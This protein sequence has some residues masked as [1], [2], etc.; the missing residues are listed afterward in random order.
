MQK[1][2]AE[3]NEELFLQFD[4]A[5]IFIAEEEEEEEE[6]EPSIVVSLRDITERKRA[7]AQ[8]ATALESLRESEE[9][10]RGIF[11]SASDTFL[12][13]NPEGEIID[14]N[15]AACK[16]YGYTHDELIGLSGK[17]IVHPDYYNIFE[18]FKRQ[19]KATGFFHAESVD[20][21]KDGSIFNIEVHGVPYNYRRKQHLLAVVRNITERKRAE[22][23][24]RESRQMMRLVLD[25]IPVR[26][27]W[28]DTDSNYLGCNKMVALDSGFSSPEELIGKNDWMMGW[29]NEAEAYRA[30]DS[31]VIDSGKPKLNYEEPQTTPDGRT[32]WVRTSKI[33][34]LD[35]AGNIKGVLGTYEDI[36]ERKRM[37]LIQHVLYQISSA[38]HA[39]KSISELSGVIQQ[40]LGS[41]IDT[42]NFFIALYNKK[43]NTL[44]LPYYKD[45]T[46]HFETFPAGKTCTAYVIRNDRPLL[47]DRKKIDEL[48]KAGEVEIVGTLSKVWLGVPLKLGEEV[49]G[50]IV[51]QSYT[52]E[53]AYSEKDLEILEFVAR[54]VG[55]FIERK[56]V[57]EEL[58]KSEVRF[59]AIVEDQ[60]EI[61]CRYLPDGTLTFVNN[62]YCHYFG[63]EREDLIGHSFM[64][65]I[66]EEDREIVR[67]KFSSLC[68]ENP[69][70]T[71]EY[72]VLLSDNRTRWQQWTDRA[73]YDEQGN[74]VEY[75][76]VGRDITELKQVVE[77]LKSAH[78]YA[79]N[80]IDSSLDMIIAVDKERRIVE[81]NKAAEESFGY[82]KAEVLGKHID[83]LYANPAEGLKT[84]NITRTTG[85]FSA[86]IMNKRK[87]GGLFPAFLSASILHDKR[88]AFLGIMGVSR[89]I[90]KLKQSEKE[91]ENL[92]A[93]L[94]QSQKVEAIGKLASGIAH[95]FNN[96]LTIISGYSQL[97]L[98]RL[99]Q[100]TPLRKNVEKIAKAGEQA[101][102]L[103]RQ[104]LAFSRKQVLESKVLDLNTVV[105][106]VEKML[107]RLI[108]EDIKI[109]IFL[110]PDLMHVKVDP[111]QIEQVIM[112]LVVNARDAMPDGGKITV[113][114]ENVDID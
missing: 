67:Q 99:D 6:E 55:L 13:I 56:R 22:E 41:I 81:F 25:T 15:P 83:I 71:Y 106:D 1:N 103:T 9:Q 80:L 38:V 100:N 112:N 97:L 50:A 19:V 69:I 17:D 96:I 29:K 48:V 95:D 114:T 66:P 11:E 33:P 12:I 109:D 78:E 75:Q 89:D 57:E 59:R 65:S 45:E 110:A 73:I 63:K 82:I 53:N 91:R 60:T 16:M 94:L 14:A 4:L 108:G 107:E 88:G 18:D 86:E 68:P 40:E 3:I 98:E 105:T 74:L 44:S 37:E 5:R 84:H 32:I 34:L 102:S 104:L 26:V 64:P 113:R 51:V 31:L 111:G 30:D 49:T 36:T 10:Y 21:R 52:D 47:A 35:A 72:R 77:E 42:K 101:A 62:A 20:V 2:P 23:A 28:K 92:Q 90:T 85:R 43:D 8:R 24:L 54:E 79:R 58:H 7:E 87:N 70:V 27:F 39:T 93:Q 61:I 76:S 46:D